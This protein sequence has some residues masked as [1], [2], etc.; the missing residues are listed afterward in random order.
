MGLEYQ[1]LNFYKVVKN[2][3]KYNQGFGPKSVVTQNNKNNRE[4]HYQKLFTNISHLENYYNAYFANKKKIR[5][6]KILL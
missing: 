4:N 1:H 3:N 6:L 5:I 2:K